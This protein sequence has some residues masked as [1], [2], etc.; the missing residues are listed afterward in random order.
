[1]PQAI[2]DVVEVRRHPTVVRL[3]HL[4]APDRGWIT[5]AYHLTEEVRAH[6]EVLDRVLSAACGSGMFLIGPYGSGKSHFLAYVAEGIRAGTLAD[7]GPD[8]VAISLV[9]FRSEMALEDIVAGALGVAVGGDRRVAWSELGA[10]YP[11]GLL[12]ILDEVSEFLRSKAEPAR[13]N[14]DVRFLQFLGEW[15]AGVRLWVL[16]A[17]QEALEHSGVLERGLYRKIK[18]RYPIRFLLGASHVRDVI[19]DSVLVKKAGYAAAVDRVAREIRAALPG[20][21]FDEAALRAVYPVHPA[22]LELLDEVRDRFSEARGVVDFAVTRLA[23][24]PARHVEPFLDRSLGELLTPDAIVDHFH[25]LLE[26]Q[27][28]FAPLA[29]RVLP[30][31]AKR[32]PE[33]FPNPA[34]RELAERVLKL[35]ILVHLA[36]ARSGLSVDDALAWLLH[37]ASRLEPEKNRGVLQ[38]ILERLREEGRFVAHAEG[39][40]RLD[41]EDGGSAELERLLARERAD[42]EARG[43]ALLEELLATL[44]KEMPTPF[45][46]PLEKWQP[47]EVRWHF[48]E[49]RIAV[50]LGEE[51]PPRLEY[52]ALA[53]CVRL[54]WGADAQVSEAFTLRP[55]QI[56]VGPE[57][58]ELVAVERLRARRWSPKVAERLEA[59]RRDRLEILKAR[60]RSAYL[61]AQIT[62]PGAAP[63]AAPRIDPTLPLA[64]W[65]EG[66]A[67]WMLRRTYPS[68]ERFAPSHGPLPKEV[69]RAYMRFAS[70][71]RP[72]EL[73]P[74]DA[75]KLVR[76]AYLVPMGLL[77]RKG[78][79]YATPPR[80]A[81]HELVKLVAAMLDHRPAPRAIYERLAA[82]VYGLVP[83]QVS[84]LLAFLSLE[85]YLEIEK[86]GRGY[87]ELYETL[88]NPIQYDRVRPAEALRS[89]QLRELGRLCE[90][91]EVQIPAQW[92]VPAQRLVAT[93]LR[94]VGR[95]RSAELRALL[96]RLE[97]AGA[98]DAL[99]EEVRKLLA[100]WSA[101][102]SGA[103]ELRGLEQLLREIGSASA[104][105]AKVSSLADLPRRIDRLTSGLQRYRHLL[106]HPLLS[107]SRDVTA[108]IRLEALGEPP[109]LGSPEEV[110]AWLARAEATYGAYKEDYR[111]R[112][113]AW[114]REWGVHPRLEWRAPAVAR[115]RHLGLT[116]DLAKLEELR[117]RASALRCQRAV[118]LDFQ[119]LCACGF[120]GETS[121]LRDVVAELEVLSDRIANELARFFERDAIRARVRRWVS[122]GLGATRETL[123]YLEGKAPHPGIED[124]QL[125]DRYLAGVD[126]VAEVDVE[127][128][129][130]AF[131]E[132]TWEG[133]ELASAFSEWLRRFG[134]RR[135]RVVKPAAESREDVALWCAEQAL[136][137]GVRLPHGL[138]RSAL[139]AAAQEIRAEWVGR[140]ALAGLEELGLPAT[141]EESV[142]GWIADG[143]LP[144]PEPEGASSLVR[145]ALELR[146]AS[147]PAT[148]AELAGM[149]GELYRH[150]GRM[151]RVARDRW[152][153]RLDSLATAPLADPPPR[154]IDALGAR[155]EIP[156]LVID[157]LGAPLAATL[158]GEIGALLPAW[159]LESSSF[160]LAP[161]GTTT[162]AFYRELA[163]AGTRHSLEK[164][165]V[166]DTLLHD[167]F[168]ELE[169]LARLATA[170]LRVAC[171][172][173]AARLDP[174]RPLLVLADHGFRIARDGRS[175]VHGGG[176]TLERLVPVWLLV[177][178]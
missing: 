165:N 81:N 141:V 16:A 26:I 64:R 139:E 73:D 143:T 38:R 149:A 126:V 80:L 34:L 49:R 59:L 119:P 22:T 117:T 157:A 51:R 130:Q 77:Q 122:D 97:A 56:A 40:Y 108:R 93:R 140:A 25:D 15:A 110:D 89:D 101:L 148:A 178:A 72:R 36:P 111:R 90:G 60:I 161:E 145:A 96:A 156:W 17:M 102:D 75:V 106:H 127:A 173:V 57:I 121:P 42:L 28:E 2:R 175:Y 3:D 12:L 23:G 120:D 33:M 129:A 71:P 45:G 29:E 62:A 146:R 63:E 133:R 65:I 58:A 55:A 176:S 4:A 19:R 7:G 164:L 50:Y 1:M 78:H 125:L 147:M 46:L 128:L 91:L 168:P 98:D 174:E 61:D 37:R 150:H 138:R 68:F 39:V 100:Q 95:A 134:E 166:L 66:Y 82:P 162:D 10:R 44:E 74:G 104:F 32:L 70:A 163:G 124:V 151:M 8:V 136:R 115:S 94:D 167:R 27:A 155:G 6:L 153:E 83:D 30:Y 53:L 142:L 132:R 152:L 84:L 54:P 159:H 79:E 5:A 24:D 113:D 87:R 48:H 103:D 11:R 137:F 169:D 116:A 92:S 18:D 177:P 114:W 43:E 135:L 158:E 47:R 88:P 154:L 171:R 31:Y 69:Y 41:L 67:Q 20:M 131:G 160:A 144:A 13:F 14:E 9:N 85:G 76:E 118:D 86:E 52:E 123:D 105:L 112:H 99:A 35:L 109:G 172:A 21:P 170:E 107:G